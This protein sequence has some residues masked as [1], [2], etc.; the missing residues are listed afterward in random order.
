MSPEN[1]SLA[2]FQPIDTNLKNCR[3]ST[4]RSYISSYQFY[5][6]N[7]VFIQM[8]EAIR[9]PSKKVDFSFS[10]WQDHNIE[11]CDLVSKCW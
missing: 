7:G 6:S 11:E 5:E 9:F 4:P 10:Q 8:L 3:S 1:A 2:I